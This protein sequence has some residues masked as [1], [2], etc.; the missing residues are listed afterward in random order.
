M[1]FDQLHA[2]PQLGQRDEKFTIVG[3][4]A[5]AGGLE[6]LE[7]FF[8]AM[9]A[10]SGMS[11][12]VVQHLSPD[13]KSHMEELLSRQTS[14]PVHRVENGIAVEPNAIYLLPPKKEMEI[15]QGK[16]LLID[17]SHD[18]SMIHPIDRFLK[19]L[20]ADVGDW[21]WSK[22]LLRPNSMACQ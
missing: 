22:T 12:V 5:S 11:F 20:A 9:P 3:I 18:R 1:N 10:D 7:A 13:F 14:I 4:G 17:R 19:S 6:A 15:N 21:Y 8:Q 16:L 2:V